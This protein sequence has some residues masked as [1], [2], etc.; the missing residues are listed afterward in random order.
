[1]W[2]A[3]CPHAAEKKETSAPAVR[4]SCMSP[5]IPERGRFSPADP[6]KFAF[7]ENEN[8]LCTTI[9]R[10]S[11]SS[12]RG[13]DVI[14]IQFFKYDHNR[15]SQYTEASTT[16]RSETGKGVTG[17]RRKVRVQIR[18]YVLQFEAQRMGRCYRHKYLMS[19]MLRIPYWR[20]QCHGTAS[21]KWK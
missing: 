11:Q 7:P 10:Y 19:P 14:F 3:F 16:N 2:P 13:T 20:S 17:D 9:C 12:G 1:M 8:I 4:I 5:L 6:E 21:P 15:H 18:V